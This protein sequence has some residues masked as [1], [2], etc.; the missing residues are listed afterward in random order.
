MEQENKINEKDWSLIEDIADLVY[1]EAKDRATKRDI[2]E[3][4]R[5]IENGTAQLKPNKEGGDLNAELSYIP[6]LTLGFTAL[7]AALSYLHLE[8]N[9]PKPLP[10]LSIKERVNRMLDDEEF[11]KSNP[12]EVKNE[13]LRRKKKVEDAL[14]RYFP[15]EDDSEEKNEES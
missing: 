1:A 12:T 11:A 5:S 10:K 4:E 3:I 8:R 14:K 13:L 7:D 9:R 15:D 2:K 6:I